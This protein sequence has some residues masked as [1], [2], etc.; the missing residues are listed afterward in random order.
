MYYQILSFLKNLSN[1]SVIHIFQLSSTPLLHWGWIEIEPPCQS[2]TSTWTRKINF[3]LL[4]SHTTM[5]FIP[6]FCQSLLNFYFQH[7]FT[8]NQVDIY[9]SSWSNGNRPS[10]CCLYDSPRTSVDRCVGFSVF[11][12]SFKRIEKQQSFVPDNYDA[13]RTPS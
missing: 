2:I 9:G 7:T 11:F 10:R 6:P 3:I 1:F 4:M 13:S 5:L 12:Y 8:H